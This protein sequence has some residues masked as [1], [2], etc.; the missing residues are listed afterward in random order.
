MPSRR[1]IIRMTDD[2]VREFL[3]GRR[4]MS[5]ATIGKDGH[6]H[7]VAMWYGF[8]DGVPAF[9]TYAKSQKILNL[10]RDPRITCL[11]EEGDAYDQLR[12]VELVGKGTVLDDHDTVVA[13][14]ESVHER[15]NGPLNDE[16]RAVLVQMGAKRAAVRIDV[17]SIVSWDHRKLGGVY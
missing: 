14:G 7:L 12:G 15:Y 16:V 5:V 3:D 2:E 4:T 1:E 6:P 17:D 11:V 9:W 8:L 13:L 10:R